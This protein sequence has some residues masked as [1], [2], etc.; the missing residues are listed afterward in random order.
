M[1][2]KKI[3]RMGV[4]RPSIQ[5]T[6]EM[7]VGSDTINVDFL[8][9]IRQFHW[10]EISL[11]FDKGDKCITIYDSYNAELAAKYIKTIKLSN[12]TEIYSLLNEKKYDTNNLMQKHLLFKQFVSWACNGF[13]KA[14]FSDYVNNHVY[15]ELIE[16]SNYNGDTS[17]ERV[18]L[19]LRASAG[20]TTEM[21]KSERNE[22]KINL[23]IQLKKAGTKK[24]RLRIW[25]YSL[26]EYL[27]VLLRQGLSLRHRTYSIVQEDDHFLE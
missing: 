3:L 16:E 19:D 26:G 6:Y 11:L 5:K 15:Q 1:V 18:Y 7:S 13:S 22:S 20:Y 2:S 24:L 25:A 10:L 4:Q 21:E 8:G 17:D 9:S 27:Y 23:F 12:F 14:P